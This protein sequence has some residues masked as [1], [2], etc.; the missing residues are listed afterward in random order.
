MV[1]ALQSPNQ[2]VVLPQTLLHNWTPSDLCSLLAST[3]ACLCWGA[4]IRVSDVGLLNKVLDPGTRELHVPESLGQMLPSSL[5]FLL[6]CPAG[7]LATECHFLIIATFLWIDW[8]WVS[9]RKYP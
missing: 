8:L 1:P 7:P 4:M 9:S 5:L 2:T 6:G 3:R